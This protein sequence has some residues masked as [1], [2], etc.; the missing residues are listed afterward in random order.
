MAVVATGM[1]LLLAGC[2]S[3]EG[4]PTASSPE[5]PSPTDSAAASPSPEEVPEL[6][7]TW[8]TSSVS[9]RDV[10]ATL[11]RYDLAEFIKPFRPLTPIPAPTVLILVIEDEWDLYGKSEGK[12]RQEIDY[13]ADYVVEGS[14]VIV[15]H[16]DGS[17]THRW[18][19]EGDTLT[20]EWLGSTLPPFQGIP[21]EV[22][23]RA[24]YMTIDF[25][26]QS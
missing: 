26:R 3:D 14:K 7:G 16:A 10:E 12:P 23:Q 17:N 11:R 21:E 4:A 24:L 20:I 13:D 9:P 22:F 25:T 18:S 8:R 15:K 5:E 2:G 1:S 19:V 6:E